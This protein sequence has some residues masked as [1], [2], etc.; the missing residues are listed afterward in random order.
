MPSNPSKLLAAFGGL[1][2]SVSLIACGPP[3]L[4][5]AESRYKANSDKLSAIITRKPQA[6]AEIDAKIAEFKAEFEKAGKEA[7]EEKKIAAIASLSARMERYIEELEPT[8]KETKA[9]GATAPSN[10]L[11]GQTPPAGPVVAPVDKLSGT[12]P[13]SGPPPSG[14]GGGA[15]PTVTAPT[16]TP[17]PTPAPTAAPAG[18][19]GGM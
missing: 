4:Q 1:C 10:K 19:M 7:A 15:T 17:T 3:T 11:D 5:G 12:P 14:M 18:G 2:L 16:P 6:K 9:G 8:P 13:P